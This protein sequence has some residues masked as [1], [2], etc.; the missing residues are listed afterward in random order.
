MIFNNFNNYEFSKY[1]NNPIKFHK[2]FKFLLY[3]F[4]VLFKIIKKRMSYSAGRYRSHRVSA[5]PYSGAVTG[6]ES[7]QHLALLEENSFCSSLRMF[8][9]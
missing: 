9:E 7:Y 1:I 2:F 4:K 5:R 3:K 6:R 8:E